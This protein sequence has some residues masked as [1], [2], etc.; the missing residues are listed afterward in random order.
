MLFKKLFRTLWHYKAQ[1]ISMVIMIALGVGVFLGFNIEWYSLE[2]NT[3]EI[4]EATGFSDYRIYSEKGFSEKDL[5]AV[6]G[7]QGVQDATRFL[8]VNTLVKGDTDVIALTVCENPSVSGFMVM[9]GEAYDPDDT[10]GIWLS[11]SYAKANGLDLGDDLTLTYK[12]IE[13]GG[14][15]KGLVKASEYLICLP[16]ET[17]MMPDYTSYGFAYI[18]PVMLE[19]AIPVLLRKV[20]GDSFYYQI[21]VRSALPKAEFVAEADKALGRTLLVL[22]KAETISWAE[23]Q[24]EVEEGKTMGSILPVLFLAIAILTMVTTMHR[25]TAS[26]KTQIGTLKAL[27]FRERRILRHYSSYALIIGIMGS[28]LGIGIG[29]LLGWYIMNPNSAM[30]TYIDM[31]SWHLYTPWFCWLVLIAINVFLTVIGFMS[32]KKMLEGTAADAL[33]PYTP[34]KIK[35]LAVEETKRFKAL[36]FSTKWNLRDCLRHKS[37]TC[38]TLFGIVG[39]MVLLVGGL[40]MKDTADVFVDVF[41][42]KANNYAVKINLDTESVSNREATALAQRYNGDWTAQQSVQIGDRGFSL[43]IYS[44][45]HDRVRF[46]DENMKLMQL[47]DEGAYISSRIAKEFG[48]GAGDTLSFSPYGGDDTYTV[49]ISGVIRS[50]TESVT[51][52]Q[53]YARSVGIPFTV[54]SIFTDQTDIEPDSHILNT[55]TKQAIMDSF[56]TFMELM[57]TMIY[58]LVL[59]AV[60]LGI[61]VLYNLGVMS[62]TERYREMATL[63]VVGFKNS[64]IGRL[65][66]EQNLW[67]SILGIIVGLPAG[68]GVLQYLLD[69]LASEYEMKL[70]LGP[71]TYI[72]PVM[73]TLLVSLIVGFM[74]A[75]KNRSIDMVAALKTEE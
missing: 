10:D 7:I 29:Y 24:G 55:Q 34:K 20:V 39:C 38:M 9:N 72:V 2:R 8:S 51:M 35:H 12:T 3:T 40:G 73:L 59:A 16:D 31:P 66:I 46:A 44:I 5:A 1:F 36:S 62:Y 30:G 27:G 28:I 57:N 13:I 15:V 33:R 69:A 49:R 6:I 58:L 64:R 26:E 52:T 45:T 68:I 63:K 4:Y 75:R 67:L 23:A 74:V 19:N 41:F 70:A 61:V 37:R 25:I 54:S 22:S 65:L 42:D 18:S 21:N 17:Q 43:D 32:V 11:D 47:G 48:V 50:L 56:N 14:T 60:I 71:A 53:E